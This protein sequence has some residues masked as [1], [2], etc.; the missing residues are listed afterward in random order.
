MLPIRSPNTALPPLL[1]RHLPIPIQA[2]RKLTLLANLRTFLIHDINR[3]GNQK[4]KTGQNSRCIFQRTS[5]NI[6]IHRRRIER[7]NTSQEVSRQVVPACRGRCVGAV[8][9]SLVINGRLVDG[10]LRDVSVGGVSRGESLHLRFRP[11]RRKS[12]LRSRGFRARD[13]ETSMRSR[14]GR[15]FRAGRG[16][17][18]TI[19]VPPVSRFL[20]WSG[21]VCGSGGLREDTRGRR[22]C[23]RSGAYGMINMDDFMV[24]VRCGRGSLR[25]ESQADTDGAKAPLLVHRLE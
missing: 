15:W 25:N 8:G 19:D 21:G 9:R 6:L 20:D 7:R 16:I 13:R 23:S 18:A 12:W 14:R 10:V 22:G 24:W 2:L 3:D 17:G 5:R 4:G 11:C 1:P